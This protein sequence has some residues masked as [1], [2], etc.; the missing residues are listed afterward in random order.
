MNKNIINQK[1]LS[2]ADWE[3]LKKLIVGLRIMPPLR[4]CNHRFLRSDIDG[5]RDE[6]PECWMTDQ[7][8]FDRMLD[9]PD[10]GAFRMCAWSLEQRLGTQGWMPL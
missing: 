10:G 3:L 7:Q 9:A 2:R 6:F 5:Y 1:R 4:A 8:V